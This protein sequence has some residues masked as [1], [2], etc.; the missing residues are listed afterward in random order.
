M[1]EHFYKYMNNCTVIVTAYEI[2]I[3][4]YIYIYVC[5]FENR[6]YGKVYLALTKV[7]EKKPSPKC[8]Q[9]FTKLPRRK[10]GFITPPPKITS[11]SE[12]LRA[13]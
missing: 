12:D 5:L 2:Y 9:G 10:R 6:A 4:I 1:D 7:T 8:G 11:G 13:Q 3:Y